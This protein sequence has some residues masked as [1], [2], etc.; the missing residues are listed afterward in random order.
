MSK[1]TKI[2][3]FFVFF[4][5]C[6]SVANVSAQVYQVSKDDFSFVES[7]FCSEKGSTQTKYTADDKCGYETDTRTCCN[8]GEW[9]PWNED[10][11]ACTCSSSTK[12]ETEQSCKV[13]SSTKENG[14]Q[15]RS[16]TCDYDTCTWKKG[17]WGECKC[18]N[19]CKGSDVFNEKTCECCWASC[20]LTTNIN[21]NTSGACNCIDVQ[22]NDIGRCCPM[23]NGQE[24]RMPASFS[25]CDSFASHLGLTSKVHEPYRCASLR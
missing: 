24:Y 14:K 18:E 22:Y 19:T 23:T 16:V 5:V 8:S 10:C 4:V 15:T 25:D 13:G 17:S 20:Y 1:I 12:P 2:V 3:A 6:F 9:S 21:N 11:P 7:P